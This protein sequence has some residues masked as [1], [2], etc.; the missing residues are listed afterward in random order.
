MEAPAPKRAANGE[1]ETNS[2]THFTTTGGVKVK[3]TSVKVDG[4]AKRP[5]V[6]LVE[7]TVPH[8]RLLGD[9]REHLT[10]WCTS[11]MRLKVRLPC[12]APVKPFVFRMLCRILAELLLGCKTRLC[13]L[14]QI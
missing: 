13:L 14:F 10:A 5:E 6:G 1:S 7:S 11:W 9:V 4:H 2:L 12:F 8:P 3:R